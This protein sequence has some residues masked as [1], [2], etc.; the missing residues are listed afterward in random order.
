M[1]ITVLEHWGACRLLI[2]LLDH[3]EGVVRARYREEPLKLGPRGAERC[4]K[5]LFKEGLIKSANHP[6]KLL[7]V[8][9][10]RGMKVANKLKE[11]SSI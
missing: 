4:H 3:P 5:L 10:E 7:F 9:T 8:L 2:F 11:I 1:R 6:T